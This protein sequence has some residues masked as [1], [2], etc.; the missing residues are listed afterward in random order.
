MSARPYPSPLR[1]PG[2]KLKVANYVKYL[3]EVNDLLDG[4]YA[5]PY[6]GGASVALSLLFG[7]YAS[8]IFINDLDL[9]VYA[10]WHSVLEETE[11]LAKRITDTKVDLIERENQQRIL[12]SEDSSLLERGFAAFYLNRTNRSGIILGGVIGGKDQTGDWKVDARF[13]KKELIRR[14]KKIA[15][16]RNCI[17][18]SNLDAAVFLDEVVPKMSDRSLTYL[19]PPYYVKG[20]GLYKNAYTPEEHAA[21]AD[22]VIALKKKWLV[23]Y[24]D[25]P[26]IIELYKDFRPLEYGLT[27]SA[28]DRRKGGEVMFFSKDLVVPKILNPSEVSDQAILKLYA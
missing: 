11:G 24:D 23:S 7:E 22:K 18:L 20:Q 1:Y 26:E 17:H 16:H 5:E 2:G 14:I 27:Y 25:A 19:D 15:R 9:A 4:D 6:A 10:F 28:Q 3:F 12:K 13:N 21:V 8:R